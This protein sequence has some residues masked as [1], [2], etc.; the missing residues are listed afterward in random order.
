MSSKLNR[1]EDA[2]RERRQTPWVRPFSLLGPIL[3]EA[4]GIKALRAA[5][6]QAKVYYTDGTPSEASDV[7]P[8]PIRDAWRQWS[9]G[10]CRV[11]PPPPSDALPI[12]KAGAE[13]W[14]EARRQWREEGDVEP[15][16]QLSALRAFREVH[17][18]GDRMSREHI[19]P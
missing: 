14:A 17:G 11:F 13:V 2:V 12:P 6:K 10:V 4:G 7:L 3:M 15:L 8:Q 18:D 16:L 5:K 9:D 1:I 19:R